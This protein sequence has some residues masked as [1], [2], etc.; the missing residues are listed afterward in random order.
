[1]LSPENLQA[2]AGLEPRDAP[3]ASRRISPHLAAHFITARAGW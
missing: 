2:A 3:H 1:M